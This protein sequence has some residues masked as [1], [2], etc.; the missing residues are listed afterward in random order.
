[1][2]LV[3]V[4][5]MRAIEKASDA[6][7][8]SYAAMMERAGAAVADVVVTKLRERFGLETAGRH[9]LVLVGPGNNGGDGLVAARILRQAGAQVTCY[10]FKAR[11]EDDP[12]LAAAV[13]K[14]CLITAAPDDEQWRTLRE[15]VQ[16]VDVLVDALLGTGTARPIEGDM[17][18]LLRAVAA[19]VEKRRA[20][21]P[22][23]LLSLSFPA[24]ESARLPLLVGVDGPTGMNYDSGELDPL[25]LAVDVSVTF[26]YPKLG[27]L[28]FPAAGACGELIV[29]DIG[30]DSLAGGVDKAI[31]VTLEV[32]DPALVRPLLP[33]RPLDAHKG[34]FG[35]LMVVAGS[36]FYSGAS[37]LAAK[38]AYRVGSG[39]VTLAA[40]RA[41][42]TSLASSM[43]ET[44]YLILPDDMGVVTPNAAKLLADKLA[45]YQV[46]LVGPGLSAE[47]E[48]VAFVQ[49]LFGI[50]PA[51]RK[52]IGFQTHAEG[53]AGQPDKVSLPPLVVDADGLNALASIERWWEQL[54]AQTI[55]TPHPGEMA[56]LMKLDQDKERSLANRWEIAS[57]QAAAWGHVVV[58]KGA[59]TVVASP[60]GRTVV[61]PFANPA[62]ATAGSGDVLA[63]AIAGLLGQGPAPFEAALCGAY[64]HG[65][66][67]E[68]ARREI[69]SA[70]VVAGDVLARLPQALQR[71]RYAPIAPGWVKAS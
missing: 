29:A 16:G 44:T 69:G 23:S 6:A 56:R 12:N 37:V 53:Q 51:G 24:A 26:A 31:G 39:L 60:Q 13:E 68:L 63:G 65:L 35:K 38:A 28:R 18:A 46:M 55:L 50:E 15:E 52:S 30:T 42:Y 4:E 70:G 5:Q 40:P 45:A 2:K 20:P 48:A 64:L 59:F 9:V 14:G 58:L 36:V 43:S 47:K 71:L 1:M 25:A 33:S 7:G 27:H 8:Y 3:S 66:A 22:A 57:Q 61:L 17:A 21:G 49:H 54:P 67:G 41:I 32:A 19:E 11:A 10:L 34:S 62:L